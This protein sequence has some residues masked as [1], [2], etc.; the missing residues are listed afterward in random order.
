MFCTFL[1][2]AKS[3][4]FQVNSNTSPFLRGTLL[5]L[6]T[7]WSF[8]LY[9]HRLLHMPSQEKHFI[10]DTP[11]HQHWLLSSH[12]PGTHVEQEQKEENNPKTSR[13]SLHCLWQ[14]SQIL[15]HTERSPKL[16]FSLLPSA[17]WEQN[18]CNGLAKEPQSGPGNLLFPGFAI[19]KRRLGHC[20]SQA[21]IILNTSSSALAFFRLFPISSLGQWH[22]K[23]FPQHTAEKKPVHQTVPLKMNSKL[24]LTA[25]LAFKLVF[26]VMPN[27]H[28][29]L[30]MPI[31]EPNSSL[32]HRCQNKYRKNS[33]LL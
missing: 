3:S 1:F 13:L 17:S 28:L 11:V 30:A 19:L 23:A 29:L 5:S 10:A 21:R 25:P 2:L 9:F 8:P 16:F 22:G 12:C 18:W 31:L 6:Q 7:L 27:V 32:K 20:Q 24:Q 26:Q 14:L 15:S 33:Y 4:G